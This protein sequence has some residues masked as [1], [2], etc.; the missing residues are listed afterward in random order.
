MVLVQQ[1]Q[2]GQPPP[3]ARPPSGPWAHEAPKEPPSNEAPPSSSDP[4][5]LGAIFAGG[6]LLGALAA[7]ILLPPAAY[8]SN[9]SRWRPGA[10]ERQ[11]NE[12][13]ARGYSEESA[14]RIAASIGRQKYGQ[15]EMTRR[16]K[17]GK[18][19]KQRMR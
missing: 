15:A 13:M 17:L 14:R 6:V 8:R 18:R 10:F 5:P 16:A 12:L 3:E 11:V 19:A 1:R 7:W 2:L 9:P 4:P